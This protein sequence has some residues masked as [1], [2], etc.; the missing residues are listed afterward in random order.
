[1]PPFP[2][3]F[4]L[5]ALIRSMAIVTLVSALPASHAFAEGQ[6]EIN[7]ACAAAGCFPGDAPG[8]P[9]T[10]S[11]PGSY[12]LT[13]SINL[14]D[15]NDIGIQITADHVDLDLAGFKIAG[16]NLTATGALF[17][18]TLIVG[19]FANHAKV[20]NGF[21]L[22]AGR[23]GIA[24][25]D[26]ALVEDVIVS[27][28]K[29]DGIILGDRSV[30]RF[31]IVEDNDDDNLVA[32]ENSHIDRNLVRGAGD[33]NIVVSEGSF[34]TKNLS[35]QAENFGLVILGDTQYVAYSKNV[36][37]FNNSPESTNPQVF[38]SAGPTYQPALNV[39]GM[40]STCP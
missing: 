22:N 20:R 4:T 33:N 1:M 40:D 30:V 5:R 27:G 12:R 25:G 28:S 13:S 16:T 7:A 8:L 15:T 34:V 19:P 2:L 18:G 11:E 24:L 29:R 3:C 9:I 10:L 23:D 14:S 21:V 37:R 32:T 38:V 26:D 36:F 17:A 31:C 39:C 35:S 6:L